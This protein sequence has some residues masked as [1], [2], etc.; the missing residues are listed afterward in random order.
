MEATVTR[1]PRRRRLRHPK[2]PRVRL[3]SVRFSEQEALDVEA[4][5]R[6]DGLNTATWV[7]VAAVAALKR[8]TA[9]TPA[10]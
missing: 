4:Q 5:A 8:A 2:A 1:K 6:A 9:A 10:V 3:I 7:R